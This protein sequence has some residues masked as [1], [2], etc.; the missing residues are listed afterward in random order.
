MESKL[1]SRTISGD[2]VAVS[3]P[4]QLPEL[5]AKGFFQ[6]GKVVQVPHDGRHRDIADVN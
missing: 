1:A 3:H 4:G 6:H 2:A 5:F